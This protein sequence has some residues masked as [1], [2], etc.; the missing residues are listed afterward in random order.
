MSEEKQSEDQ[1]V[2]IDSEQEEDTDEFTLMKEQ[3][4]EAL[5]E[6]D[7]F[8]ALAQ[9][10]QADFENYRKRVSSERDELRRNAN[11][12][13]ILKVLSVADNLNRAIDY[14]PKDT[15][16]ASWLEGLQLVQRNVGNVLDSE[17]VSKIEAE[18]QPFEPYEH[19]AVF[20]EETDGVEEGMV[21]SVIRDG[22][23]LHDKVLRA[24]QVS[25]S[26]A[27]EKEDQSQSESTEQE[28]K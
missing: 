28:A 19:E 11:T 13:L 16:D 10:A 2:P 24:A 25:V 12:Q 1:D 8:R 17:G 22:Y 21:V 3:M 7:Q 6:K 27:P 26:K 4:E 5:R 14:I 9:R 18:G 15:V 20:Y 23:K